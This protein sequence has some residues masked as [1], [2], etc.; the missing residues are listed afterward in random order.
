MTTE[1]I[2]KI[3]EEIKELKKRMPAHSVPPSMFQ[4]LDELEIE[5]AQELEKAKNKKENA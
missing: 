5:L 2:K 1:R 3:R 4:E